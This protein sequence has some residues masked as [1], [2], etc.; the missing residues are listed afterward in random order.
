MNSNTLD[1]ARECWIEEKS[2]YDNYGYTLVEEI[3]EIFKNANIPV[4]L[5][6]RTKEDSS[7][8]KKMLFKNKEYVELHDKVGVRAIVHFLSD[9]TSSDVLIIDKFKKR[10]VKRESKLE[11][12]DEKTFGYLSIHYDIINNVRSENPMF[13][14]LQLRTV[15]QNAWAEMAH[16]ISYKSEVN[17]PINILREM[18]ALS[19]LMEIADNQFQR[20]NDLINNLPISNPHKI[21][22]IIDGF[23]YSNIAG[24]YD[25]EM[26]H[27]FLDNISEIYSE[28]EDIIYC[29]KNFIELNG[30]DI[31]YISERRKDILFFSQP[32]II[33]ILERLEKK[34]NLLEE[35][36]IKKYPLD[37]LEDIANVWGRSINT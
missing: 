3:K 32:E 7:L 27:Y 9:L 19:A 4:T 31:S 30:Q 25:V 17:L 20:I 22:K 6:Y 34:P 5:S 8:L 13:C 33:V 12:S 18:N 26:S 1:L 15:C 37:H 29:L 28:D 35:Y 16:I 24:W 11:D 14:E 2:N 23:F 21:L 36:W 10:I